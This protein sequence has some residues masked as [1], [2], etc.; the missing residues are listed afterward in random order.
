[1]EH[2]CWNSD[3]PR[4]AAAEFP[5]VDFLVELCASTEAATTSVLQTVSEAAILRKRFTFSPNPDHH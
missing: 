4:E 3:L 5:A 1:M 2:F